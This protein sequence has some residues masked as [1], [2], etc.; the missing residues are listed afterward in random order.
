MKIDSIDMVTHNRFLN[1]YQLST[2]KR[3]GAKGTYYVASRAESPEE[4]QIVTG[5]NKPAGV[6]IFSLYG[7]KRDKVVLIRQYRFPIGGFAY[8]LPAG[9]IEKGEDF[10]DSAVREMREETGLKLTLKNVDPLFERA[11]YTTIGMTDESCATVYGYAEGEPSRKGLEDGEDIEVVL[12]DRAE[13]IRI[14]REERVA[15]NCAYLLMHFLEKPDD[16]F[17]FLLSVQQG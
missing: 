17:A 12:A 5:I 10:H 11:F 9:L 16:P 3:T 4:L 2:M 8:E 15:A 7:E 14:L 13:I 1:Y 6:V